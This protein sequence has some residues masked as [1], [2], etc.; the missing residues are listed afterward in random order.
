[1]LTACLLQASIG[2]ANLLVMAMEQEGVSTEEARSRIWMVD[3]GGLLVKVGS[4]HSLSL[5]SLISCHVFARF[6]KISNE[7]FTDFQNN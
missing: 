7:V 3:S 1:M 5:D 6:K 2:I 4:K